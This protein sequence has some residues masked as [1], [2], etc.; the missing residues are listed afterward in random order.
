MDK[1]PKTNPFIIINPGPP[2]E[3]LKNGENPDADTLARQTLDPSANKHSG[4]KKRKKVKLSESISVEDFKVILVDFGEF[5]IEELGIETDPRIIL[6]RTEDYS[7]EHI[8]FGTFNTESRETTVSI[9]NRHPMDVLRSVAHELVHHKQLEEGRLEEGSGETG[10]EIENEANAVAGA[11]MRKYGKANPDMF[12]K[13]AIRHRKLLQRDRYLELSEGLFSS[14]KKK[15]KKQGFISKAIFGDRK[16]KEETA[17]LRDRWEAKQRQKELFAKWDSE[18]KDKK[19][20]ERDNTAQKGKS[21]GFVSKLK[22]AASKVSSVV[23]KKPKVNVDAHRQH[24][25]KW[26]DAARKTSK[27]QTINVGNDVVNARKHYKSQADH[28]ANVMRSH[29]EEPDKVS[30]KKK[31]LVRTSKLK[32]PAMAEA[33]EMRLKAISKLTSEQVVTRPKLKK[34]ELSIYKED[35]RDQLKPKTTQTRKDK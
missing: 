34:D 33:F 32:P 35:P 3:D 25:A 7:S 11:L 15:P 4:E 23:K 30:S 17:K 14:G 2:I 1:N 29:G 21:S 31:K 16:K 5:V 18:V 22:S 19:K 8:T 10:S 26:S 27:D 24:H 9:T 28:H 13:E 6:K 20:K 12:S